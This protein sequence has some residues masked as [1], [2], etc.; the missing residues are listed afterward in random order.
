MTANSIPT[1]PVANSSQTPEVDRQV[2][3]QD[4]SWRSREADGPSRPGVRIVEVEV[5]PAECRDLREPVL[6]ALRSLAPAARR[7][8]AVQYALA[9]KMLAEGAL[10]AAP[11]L[12][13]AAK[14][15]RGDAVDLVYARG[16]PTGEIEAGLMARILGAATGQLF[17]YT[18]QNGGDLLMRLVPTDGGAANSQS[19]RGDH[20][21]H[22]D[23]ALIPEA[24]RVQK[25]SLYGVV[26]PPGTLTYYASMADA[27]ALLSDAH[28]AV[29]SEAHWSVKAPASFGWGDEVWSA[30]HALLSKDWLGR[31]NIAWPSYNTRQLD[32]TD[33]RPAEAVAALLAAVNAVGVGLPVDP[34]CWMSLNNL[35]GVHGRGAV[36]VGRRLLYRTYAR[37]S[38]AALRTATG[39]VGPVFDARK[40]IGR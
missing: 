30:P 36:P 34:G 18:S 1:S 21:W 5:T 13:R 35:R 11:D 9:R 25:L 23:D 8:Q 37:D 40:I 19:T 7:D 39:A 2:P 33:P 3:A 20:A 27:E 38:L 28:L 17:N 26:N 24:C 10:D 14:L 16:L 32:P 6:S 31:T 22:V 12:A 4:R 15:M 29:L